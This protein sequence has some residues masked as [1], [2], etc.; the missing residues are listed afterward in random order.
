M[1]V[2]ENARR[3]HQVSL[4]HLVAR[5]HHGFG[6]LRIV[7]EDQQAGGVQVQAPYRNDVRG[8]EWKQVV[9][10]GPSIRIAMGGEITLRLVHQQVHGMSRA[11]RLTVDGDGVPFQI[12]PVLRVADHG[13]VD[14]NA[15]SGDHLAGIGSRCDSGL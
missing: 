11:D 4:R 5:V 3:L 6:E 15:P 9:D 13:A 10:R 8:V 12:D 7:G 14:L 2:G 1:F